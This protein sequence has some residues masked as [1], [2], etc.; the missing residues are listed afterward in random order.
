M[1]IPVTINPNTLKTFNYHDVNRN[2]ENALQSDNLSDWD[3]DI[4][5]SLQEIC[6]EAIASNW[7][8]KN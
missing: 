1:R 6:L 5:K 2:V 7:E 8:G 3:Q 4:P